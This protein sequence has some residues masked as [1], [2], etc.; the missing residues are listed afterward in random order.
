[1]MRV[2]DWNLG[3]RLIMIVEE[4][5]TYEPDGYQYDAYGLR[6]SLIGECLYIAFNDDILR[7]AVE[8]TDGNKICSGDIVS[9]SLDGYVNVVYT[10]DECEVDI[11]VTNKC[12]SNCIMCPLAEGV[13]KK[14]NIG[15]YE[16]MKAYIDLLPQDISYFNITGG[17]PTLEKE[18]F[19]H[20]LSLLKNKY[21]HSEFQLLT[22][23]RSAAD[24]SFLHKILDFS[25][26]GMRYAIPLH[27]SNE[28]IHDKITQSQYSFKQTD[29]GIRNLLA[30]NQKVE[31][32]IVISKAN[33]NC[34][35]ETAQYISK[36][37]KGLYC[38]NFIGME[39]MGNA[40][41]NRESLWINYSD[42]F[43]CAKPA[44]DILIRSGI[45]VQLYNFPLC[46]V[47]RGYWHIAAKS[48][49]GY[50][51]RFMEEC[52]ACIVKEICGGFFVSTKQVMKPKVYP[53][54]KKDE[55]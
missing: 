19:L 51:V 41:K 31:I 55:D 50:K 8:D 22:N 13:R 27:S 3:N 18:N 14:Q 44:I 1:M 21:N 7:Y 43:R 48:I 34:L 36:N 49:T 40:A 5:C 10:H 26:R 30:T 45:D 6:G 37:Y 15:H 53:V 23:G 2:L 38:V 25:P 52:D 35:K 46:A 4:L 11:F 47:E 16:W 42:A 17:E 33:S 39:M 29:K 32:R 24:V 9:I 20:I 54:R 28:L 12:N